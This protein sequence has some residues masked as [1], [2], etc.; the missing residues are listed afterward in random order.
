M[1]N[2]ARG[3]LEQNTHVI[4]EAL[5]RVDLKGRLERY[6]HTIREPIRLAD[7][8]WLIIN[9]TEVHRGPA[10]GRGL[11][12]EAFVGLTA[13]PQLV[14]GERPIVDSIPLPP[15]LEAD[16]DEGLHILLD[17]RAEYDAASRLLNRELAGRTLEWGD[18][19]V[20]LRRIRVLG[21]GG[22]RMAV[23]VEFGGTLRGRVFL[24]GTPTIDERANEVWVPDLDFDVA[25]RS[26]LVS[27]AA[28]L[29][30]GELVAFLRER[31]RIPVADV[32][33]LASEQLLRGLNRELSD[34]VRLAGEV[35]RVEVLAVE[36]YRENFIVRSHA[37]ARARMEIRQET[38][39]SAAVAQSRR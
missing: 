19:R 1:I 27:G 2:A 23:E 34:E 13:S 14:L 9:P 21:I 4:D 10:G 17:G 24:V 16:L 11:T 22:G 5:G 12:L 15:L 25:T 31:A 7:D 28:W 33:D 29:A 3:Q 18:N 6:W 39:D 36:A 26:L 30:H 35:E 38:T 8:V 20:V 37:L 32:I